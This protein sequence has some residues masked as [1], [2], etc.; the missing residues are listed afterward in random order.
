M[1]GTVS[2]WGP[3]TLLQLLALTEMGL[4]VLSMNAVRRFRECLGIIPLSASYR[5]TLTERLLLTIFEKKTSHN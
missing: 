2:L 1:S 4:S 5:E 3:E